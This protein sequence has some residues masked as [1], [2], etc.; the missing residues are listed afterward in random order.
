VTL[1]YPHEYPN[2]PERCARGTSRPYASASSESTGRSPPCRGW[3]YRGEGSGT[4]HP[5]VRGAV[6]RT[7]RQAAPLRLYFLVRGHG[8]G[9]RGAA[10]C[11]DPRRSRPEMERGDELRRA[12]PGQA[13][14]VSRGNTDRQDLGGMERGADSLSV[15]DGPCQPQGGL[16]DQED[17]QE[18][19]EEEG[20]R[21]PTPNN[22]VRE[23]RER[24]KA[25]EI[26]RLLLGVGENPLHH[27]RRV[28]PLL[29]TLCCMLYGSSKPSSTWLKPTN[30]CPECQRCWQDGRTLHNS[31][32]PHRGQADRVW[33]STRGVVL[34]LPLPQLVFSAAPRDI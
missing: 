2:D 22:G 26:T 18:A 27:R 20:K 9:L 12:L 6:L 10:P 30:E 17:L 33:L 21:L 7:H 11:G 29:P 3:V 28:L 15:G 8:K 1:T 19:G 32:C 31:L 24:G 13:R 25:S 16:Q 5:T 14:G 23:A 34:L 4:S